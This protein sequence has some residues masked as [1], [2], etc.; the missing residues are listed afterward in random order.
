MGFYLGKT[1]KT[2]GASHG[3]YS[4]ESWFRDVSCV[5]TTSLRVS[6]YLRVTCV[7]RTGDPSILLN[8]NSWAYSATFLCLLRCW[9]L[10]FNFVTPTNSLFTI[11]SSRFIMCD[12][13]ILLSICT[14]GKFFLQSY[15]LSP[16]RLILVIWAPTSPPPHH[17]NTFLG[18]S[19]QPSQ[20]WVGFNYTNSNT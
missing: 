1:R 20:L 8:S 14:S 3:K 12:S 13:R 17:C 4:W 5:A 11:F 6:K 2:F 10:L 16:N 15:F 18:R 9:C 19:E 7:Y